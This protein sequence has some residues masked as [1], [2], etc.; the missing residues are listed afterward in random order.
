[1]SRSAWPRLPPLS[2]DD[3][4]LRGKTIVET[5]DFHFPPALCKHGSGDCETCGTT[6]RRE[7]L[8]RTRGGKGVVGRLG[9]R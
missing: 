7:T 5:W 8:H 2:P 9:R 1:M 4:S 3:P 6:E